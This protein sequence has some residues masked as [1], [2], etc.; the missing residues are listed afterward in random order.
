MRGKRHETCQNMPPYTWAVGPGKIPDF[1]RGSIGFVTSL[2]GRGRKSRFLG[3]VGTLEKRQYETRENQS[4]NDDSYG[5]MY[6]CSF[7]YIVVRGKTMN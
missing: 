6:T 5:Q 4:L 3:L 1:F 2:G 7:L